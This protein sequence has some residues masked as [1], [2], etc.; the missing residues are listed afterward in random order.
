M[1][2]DARGARGQAVSPGRSTTR[3]VP[4][5]DPRTRCRSLI[6]D[7]ILLYFKRH[8]Q[9]PSSLLYKKA[10]G[11][12]F[13]VTSPA[14]SPH[15]TLPQVSWI[16]P[17]SG[18][19]EHPPSP[20]AAGMWFTHQVMSA[21]VSNPKTWSKTVL[22]IMYDENDGF[23][24]HV[25]PPVPPPGTPGEYLTVDPLPTPAP[26]CRRADRPRFP[27]AAPG[28]VALQP[29]RL[30]VLRHLRP[31]VAAA[32]PRD[33]F[34]RE[35]AQHLGVASKRDRRPD[36][37]VACRVARHLGPAL[38]AT[39]GRSDAASQERMLGL[40]AHRV[41]R[42]RPC[43]VPGAGGPEPCRRRNRVAASRSRPEHADTSG[44]APEH[45]R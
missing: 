22:F 11:P 17:R 6:S 38:P 4:D 18:Y 36:L 37:N 1:A 2:L 43:A 42:H 7:N 25:K 35:G 28:G 3:R 14:T 39:E 20:P 19:D 12:L 27:G 8:V 5:T 10:F 41:R 30:R 26:R 31:H 21:L 34:R 24:D 45:E 23:F 15:D 13:P 29:G 33:A 32:V 9:D 44:V 16:I 40:A